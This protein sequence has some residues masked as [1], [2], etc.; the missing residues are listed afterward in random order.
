MADILTRLHGGYIL[1]VADGYMLNFSLVGYAVGS[2]KH[3]LP[4]PHTHHRCPHMQLPDA[5][6]PTAGQLAT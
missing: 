4:F 5:G 1:G 6:K 3:C 2:S